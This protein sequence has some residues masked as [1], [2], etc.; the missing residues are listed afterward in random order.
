MNNRKCVQIIFFDII[1]LKVYFETTAAVITGTNCI[2][3]SF[4]K[5]KLELII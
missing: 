4:W 2:C 3:M 5:M 1:D